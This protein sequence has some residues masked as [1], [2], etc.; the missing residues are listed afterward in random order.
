MA[1]A[2]LR[3]RPA[4]RLHLGHAGADPAGEDFDLVPRPCAARRGD[5]G[6]DDAGSGG[7]GEGPEDGHAEG[8]PGIPRLGAGQELPQEFAQGRGSLLVG[9]DFE[10]RRFAPG[11]ARG[12]E[13]AHLVPEAAARLGGGGLRPRE[14]HGGGADLE[15]L[16]E[17]ERLP[18]AG[19]DSPVARRRQERQGRRGGPGGGVAA[20]ALVAGKVDHAQGP[21]VGEDEGRE[22]QVGRAAEPALLGQA[23]GVGAR[24]P[25]Y[26]GALAVP[27]GARHG[28]REGGRRGGAF[29][30]AD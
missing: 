19:F 8:A 28:E 11:A 25:P 26:Q 22:A 3:D 18:R 30:H 13:G 17:L 27:G 4:V 23:V 6:D 2:R 1:R 21:P 24:K 20:A 29:F 10:D 15:E 12:Q 14:G 5:A 16:Q 7:G 9:R